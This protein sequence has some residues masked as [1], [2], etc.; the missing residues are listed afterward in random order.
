MFIL[1]I[2]HEPESC[3]RVESG[4]NG[5]ESDSREW[6][7]SSHGR[8]LALYAR[9]TRIHAWI[10]HSRYFENMYMYFAND[11]DVH[12][13]YSELHASVFEQT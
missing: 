12:S 1:S 8:A 7:I 5:G 9:S 10:L 3:I 4:Q 6:G 2:I 13:M 11:M